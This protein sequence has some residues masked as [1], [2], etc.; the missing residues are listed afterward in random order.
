MLRNKVNR[1]RKRCRK[2]YYQSKVHNLRNTNPRDWW[3]EVKQLCGTSKH[4]NKSVKDRLHQDLWQETDIN[5]SNKIN[6]V[7]INVI[8]NYVPLSED[9]A[10]IVHNDETPIIV[11]ESTI[12]RKLQEISTS[13]SSG[14]D[15]ISNWVLKTYSDILASPVANI[16]NSSFQSC[17][18]PQIWKLA[19]VVPLPKTS[20]VKDLER[21][22]RPIS[23]TS[24]LSKIAERLVIEREVKPTLLKVVDPQQFGFIPNSSTVLA[25][26]SMLHCWLSATD[27]SGSSVRT[28]FLDY[29]KAFDMV[30][31][32]TLVA[33]LFSLGIKPCVVNWI[34]DFLRNRWQRVKLSGNCFSDW[35]RVPA[36]WCPSRHTTWALAILTKS[37]FRNVEICR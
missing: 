19:D 14:P 11:T 27:G 37:P 10:V 7:F 22:L 3:R 31:H 1:E 36:A 30:D 6:N 12:A 2:S 28:V 26:I 24:T 17:K 34:I 16:I 32:T 21:E 35:L 15:G 5:L 25:L 33:K 20:T 8:Q 13:R 4:N 18:V 23:L 29:K 9:T